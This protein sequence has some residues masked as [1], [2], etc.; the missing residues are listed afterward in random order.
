MKR[1]Y[2]FLALCVAILA[3]LGGTAYLFYFGKYVFG[4]ANLGLAA[5]AW[6]WLRDLGREAMKED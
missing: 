4:V 1:F 3:A 6:P 2:F 5:M